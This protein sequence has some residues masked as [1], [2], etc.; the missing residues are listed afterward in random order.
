[1]ANET[2]KIQR[3]RVYASQILG[4]IQAHGQFIVFMDTPGKTAEDTAQEAIDQAKKEIVD[5]TSKF[6]GMDL[7]EV[8]VLRFGGFPLSE[9]PF[10]E[11]AD[12]TTLAT[13]TIR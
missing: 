2:P 7:A 6:H 4:G 13:L 10:Y 12:G 11:P 3:R 9:C 5:P 8:L 1:M